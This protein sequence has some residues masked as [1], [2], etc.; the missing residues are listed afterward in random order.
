MLSLCVILLREEDSSDLFSFCLHKNNRKEIDVDDELD[1]R[2][3]C[4][5]CWRDYL[6][7]ELNY[8]PIHTVHKSSCEICGYH[9][10]YEYIEVGQVKK[11]RKA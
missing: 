9:E 3:L 11:N 10:G 2:V 5:K 4:K 1:V 7:A 8:L 6:N